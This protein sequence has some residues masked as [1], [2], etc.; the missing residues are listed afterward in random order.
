MVRKKIRKKSTRKPKVNITVDGNWD[1]MNACKGND[2]DGIFFGL[3]LIM[4]AA[5]FYYGFQW[6][7]ALGAF[8]VF[9]VFSSLFKKK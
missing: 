6:E 3:F 9:I 4:V 1:K 5:L 2:R 7:L 8:G